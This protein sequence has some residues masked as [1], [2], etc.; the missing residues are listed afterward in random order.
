MRKSH[1]FILTLV[2]VSAPFIWSTEALA[3]SGANHSG[4]L[5]LDG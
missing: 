3:L 1:K 5:L 4:T 2:L